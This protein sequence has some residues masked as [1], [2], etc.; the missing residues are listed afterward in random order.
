MTPVLYAYNVYFETYLLCKII[1]KVQKYENL[2][3]NQA[4]KIENFIKYCVEKHF[5]QKKLDKGGIFVVSLHPR[6]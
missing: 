1:F 6:F 4:L 3:E 5:F 2:I